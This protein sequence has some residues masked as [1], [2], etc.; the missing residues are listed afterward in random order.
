M[1]DDEIYKQMYYTL[2]NCVS[3]AIEALRQGKTLSAQSILIK[4]QQNT[5]EIYI[6]QE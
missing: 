5:E 1:S 2:F 6:S 3:D 4:A